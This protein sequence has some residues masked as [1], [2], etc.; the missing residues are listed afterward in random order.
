MERAQRKIRRL[1]HKKNWRLSNLV[2]HGARRILFQRRILAR[3]FCL[4][5]SG[6]FSLLLGFAGTCIICNTK[7]NRRRRPALVAESRIRIRCGSATREATLCTSTSP[8]IWSVFTLNK[9]APS[10]QLRTPK[11]CTM[12]GCR[13]DGYVSPGTESKPKNLKII[14]DRQTNHRRANGSISSVALS[15]QKCAL[16]VHVPNHNPRVRFCRPKSPSSLPSMAAQS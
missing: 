3:S 2:A 16:F 13:G 11:H 12:S 7:K 5:V 6:F 10:F 4:A 14:E 9:G 8:S 15:L 1:S